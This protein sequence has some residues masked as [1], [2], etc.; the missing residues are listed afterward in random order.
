MQLK[1]EYNI[2]I[3]IV[4]YEMSSVIYSWKM[5]PLKKNPWARNRF[6]AP[7]RPKYVTPSTWTIYSKPEEI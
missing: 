3:D 5:F 7:A 4:H 2:F 6:S 1:M